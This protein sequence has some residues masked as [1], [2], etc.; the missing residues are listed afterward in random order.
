M[1][2]HSASNPSNLHGLFKFLRNIEHQPPGIPFSFALDADEMNEFVRALMR[3]PNIWAKI[4][5]NA[6]EQMSKT[7][8]QT[9][10]DFQSKALPPKT[11]LIEGILYKRDRISLTGRRRHGKTTLI[12]NIAIAGALGRKEYLGFKVPAPF[13]SLVFYLEDDEGELQQKLRV[14]LKG[15]PV[16][17]SFHLYT[18]DHFLEKKIRIDIGDNQFRCEVL[19]LCRLAR[20]DFIVFDN[21]AHLVG[22]D[23]NNSPKVHEVMTFTFAI[24]KELDAAVMIAAHPR[25][26]AN[27]QGHN[28]KGKPTPAV[29]LKDSPEQFCEEC[30]G[31]SHFINSTGSTWALERD[32]KTNRSHVLLGNQRISSD[33]GKLT[34]VEKDDHEWLD[35]VDDIAVAVEMLLNTETRKQAWALFPAGEFTYG[36]V[37]TAVN[38]V[39]KSKNAFTPWWNELRRL[40]L[41]V[42]GSTDG[43]W[44]KNEPI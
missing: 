35:P 11:P 6:Q 25:K 5:A 8:F 23:Y 13:R 29:T 38:Q 44:K 30:M 15:N 36:Q 16:P 24:A 33:Y 21:L 4:P 34:L 14:M 2:N 43:M 17:K 3:N 40:K 32:V 1:A 19:R 18:R 37:W 20:P 31:T 10:R 28:G 9:L 27:L 42:E 22:A 41:L 26:G 12:S 7:V 39:M